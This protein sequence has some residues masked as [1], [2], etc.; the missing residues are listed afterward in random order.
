M[1]QRHRLAI[2]IASLAAPLLACGAAPAPAP[3]PATTSVESA[4]SAVPSAS[5]SAAAPPPVEKKAGARLAAVEMGKESIPS[6][7]AKIVFE[8]PTSGPC[9][10]TSYK[11]TW[12]ASSKE[13]KLDGL[14]IPA[15]ETRERWLK[16]HAEDGKLD[17]L[18]EDKSRV[19][20]QVDC[21]R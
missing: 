3:A 8:N 20:A 2:L 4:P 16:V 10:F 18:T 5:A 19:E 14:T 17:D 13:I 21:S 15:G 9:R 6:K 1:L 7:R 11:L 12:G